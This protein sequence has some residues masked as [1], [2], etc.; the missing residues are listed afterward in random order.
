MYFPETKRVEITSGVLAH[1]SYKSPSGAAVGVVQAY[2]PSVNPNR[3]G[4]SF[5]FVADSDL[6]LQTMR[7]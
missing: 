6:A 1:R 5:W 3:N 4:W 7:S 2:N